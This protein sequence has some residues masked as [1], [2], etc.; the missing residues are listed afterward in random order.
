MY[1]YIAQDY[2]QIHDPFRFFGASINFE[3]AINEIYF[4]KLLFINNVKYL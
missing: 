2:T 3:F 1:L 4:T